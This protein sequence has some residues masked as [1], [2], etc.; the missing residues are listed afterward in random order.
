MIK[1]YKIIFSIFLIGLF[2]SGCGLLIA[3]IRLVDFVI[4]LPYTIVEGMKEK[5]QEDKK[6]RAV[7]PY[8]EPEYLLSLPSVDFSKITSKRDL[9][10]LKS[11]TKISFGGMLLEEIQT[12]NNIKRSLGIYYHNGKV[13]E[14]GLYK[15]YIPHGLWRIFDKNKY[16]ERLYKEGKLYKSVKY[17]SGKI[18]YRVEYDSEQRV[19]R[20]IRYYGDGKVQLDIKARYEKLDS[21]SPVYEKWIAYY[22][23]GNVQSSMYFKDNVPNLTWTEYYENGQIREIG[24]YHKGLKNG[25]WI[26]YYKNG[27]VLEEGTYLDGNKYGEWISYDINKVKKTFEYR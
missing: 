26:S 18:V 27:D 9:V 10:Y 17:K 7:L 22:S 11:D 16:Y 25:K 5:K 23:N 15:D 8:F 1:K 19:V 14:Y 3:P 13:M 24:A 20:D 12:K 21:N 6:R 2:F 4:N